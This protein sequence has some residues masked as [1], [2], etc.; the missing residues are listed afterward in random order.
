MCAR[1]RFS[2]TGCLAAAG[3]LWGT[4]GLTGTLFRRATG[5]SPLAVASFRLSGGGLLLVLILTLT[6][7]RWP[8]GPAAW[9]RVL[10]IGLLAA[11][12]Q[13]AYFVAVSLTDLAL[14]TLITIGSAPVIV[15]A[16]ER[17]LGLRRV[18]GRSVLAMALALTGLGLLVGLPSGGFSATA[19]LGSAMLSVA[20]AAAFATLTL[21][22]A[23]PARGLEGPGGS[24]GAESPWL[25]GPGGSRG[26]ESPWLGPGGSRGAESPWLDDMAAIGFGFTMG[27]LLLMPLAL[28]AGP[29]LFAPRP[30]GL[31]WLAALAAGP[32]AVAY[33]LYLRGL[34]SA[35]P[36]TGAL[37]S[38]LEPLTATVLAVLVLGNRL[39]AAGVTGAVLLAAAVVMAVAYRS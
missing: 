14:A 3:V 29:V 24:R 1:F 31:L 35:A 2:G 39:S 6:A 36:A 5:V 32:T 23:Q 18:T 17:V 28:L 22:S 33:T 10:I 8:N 11:G 27:G 30:A 38:L 16:A 26:A 7:R 37:L 34:R 15:L 19:V 13:S 4:G 12:F 20:S 9:R 21:V 25:E